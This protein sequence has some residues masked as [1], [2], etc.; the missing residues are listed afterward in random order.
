MI[1]FGVNLLAVL[2]VMAVLALLAFFQFTVYEKGIQ[3]GKY[4]QINML[5]A[6]GI[7][8]DW[9]EN[10]ETG[11]VSYKIGPQLEQ[12]MAQFDHRVEQ[13]KSRKAIDLKD[14]DV[15]TTER[16]P[17][18]KVVSYY[19]WLQHHTKEINM[20]FDEY[21]RTYAGGTKHFP[22]DRDRYISLTDGVVANHIFDYTRLAYDFMRWSSTK[23]G[24]DDDPTPIEKLRINRQHR[25]Y[26]KR[27]Y[28]K[29]YNNPETRR[30]VDMSFGSEIRLFGWDFDRV[31]IGMIRNPQ[32]PAFY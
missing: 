5:M 22:S 32:K 12:Q 6:L 1:I 8:L 9:Q 11:A 16:N 23:F 20:S 31:N 13:S 17:W 15:V 21:V 28:R 14:F 7:I 30:L 3:A 26:D 19:Y 4:Q 18:D 2:A 25:P 24:T 10:E 27:D 29:F